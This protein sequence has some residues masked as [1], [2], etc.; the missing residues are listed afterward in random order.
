MAVMFWLIALLGVV[1][2]ST[3]QVSTADV[4][5][6]HSSLADPQINPGA[7][8]RVVLDHDGGIDDFI[9]LLLLL[10]HRP[11][12]Q[13][14]G[15]MVTGADAMPEVALNSTL[16]LL[17]LLDASEVP[18][19]LST[20]EG[21]NPFPTAWRWQ[22]SR[23]DVLPLLNQRPHQ[24]EAVPEPAEEYLMQLLLAQEAPVD[25]VATGP[26]SN[27]AY[28]VAHGGPAVARKISCVWWMGGALA[29]PGNVAQHPGTSDG[30]AEWNAFWDPP[31]VGVLW[32]SRVPL[33]MV[34]L[35][36]TNAVPVT[37]ELLYGFGP[38][39][40]MMYSNLAGS[41][42]ASVMSWVQDSSQ[43]APYYAWDTL[44]AAC[45]L[46][47]G[48]GLCQTQLNVQT[49][50]CVG[51]ESRGRTVLVDPEALDVGPRG[52]R[53][54]VVGGESHAARQLWMSGTHSVCPGCDVPGGCQSMVKE[55]AVV[56]FVETR[57]FNEFVLHALNCST[58]SRMDLLVGR[59]SGDREAVS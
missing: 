19:A 5:R 31:A 15:V 6:D 22:G 37:P 48:Q 30:S 53:E 49:R 51:G 27:I 7:V 58:P 57:A 55:V 10:S 13:L 24:Q 46:A 52:G 25:I 11:A 36:A 44:T 41:M 29:V 39:A 8:R 18:V 47:Q 12:V 43:G 59:R 28:A 45:Y 56:T 20:I 35:D 17:D 14:V 16:K 3:G 9:T 26:L 34:P 4:A 2:T 23:V 42:W 33:V 38:Q 32:S 50:V 1:M 21:V 40:Q 54:E